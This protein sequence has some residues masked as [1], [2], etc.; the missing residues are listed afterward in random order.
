MGLT[1]YESMLVALSLDFK[2]AKDEFMTVRVGPATAKSPFDFILQITV[3]EIL[4]KI[5]R[6]RSLSLNSKLKDLRMV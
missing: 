3:I 2:A 1:G 4:K 6:S 5:R